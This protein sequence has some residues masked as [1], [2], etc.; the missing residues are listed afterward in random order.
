MPIVDILRNDIFK[1]GGLPGAWPTENVQAAAPLHVA[2]VDFF[3][4]VSTSL[5]RVTK[6]MV[7]VLRPEASYAITG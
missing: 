7:I 5:P 6:G 2:Y 3:L 4:P 1:E